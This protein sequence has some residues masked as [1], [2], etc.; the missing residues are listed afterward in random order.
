MIKDL[1]DEE[2]HSA[3]LRIAEELLLEAMERKDVEGA[4]WIWPIVRHYQN[5]CYDETR[6]KKEIYTE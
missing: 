4:S 6:C 1:S 2:L 3:L 5:I